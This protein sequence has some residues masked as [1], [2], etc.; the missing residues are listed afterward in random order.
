VAEKFELHDL[1]MKAA[2]LV[3]FDGRRE[4]EDSH[5]LAQA[6]EMVFDRGAGL[7]NSYEIYEALDVLSS[8][9]YDVKKVPFYDLGILRD[10]MTEVL[11]SDD[12]NNPKDPNDVGDAV[13]SL[14]VKAF[15]SF[16]E[17][18]SKGSPS[19]VLLGLED[20]DGIPRIEVVSDRMEE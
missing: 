16:F 2:G 14:A 12:P 10:A 19:S 6:A 11:D 15:D 4:D 13:L 20:D 9:A 3:K 5:N 8:S 18:C 7:T 1:L 17:K